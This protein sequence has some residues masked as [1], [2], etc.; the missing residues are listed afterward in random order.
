[1]Q[2]H[3]SNPLSE[4]VSRKVV[5]FD[6]MKLTNIQLGLLLT[7]VLIVIW[8]GWYYLSQQNYEFLAYVGTIVLVVA[9][10]FSTLKWSRF[11]TGV[12]VG[13]TGWGLL[14]M[15]G[16]SV[17]TADGVLY[18][19]KMLPIF[20]GGGEFYIL[21]FDQFVHAFLYGVVGL[22]FFHLLREVVGVRTHVGLIAFTAIFAA[23]G[24]SIIN[25]IVEFLAVVNL[26]ETG[27]GG[28]HNTVL[29]M[30]FNLFGAVVAVV[31]KLLFDKCKEQR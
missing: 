4:G 11:G 10:L 29:D 2:S 14:H 21:K 1:L 24:F 18:A 7:N 30:I 12:I 16:G 15:L 31:G 6:D 23:A 28:Y 9:I 26:P 25:E 27:V 19:W 20:D 8:F 3:L 22:M 13:V 5:Y 17:M